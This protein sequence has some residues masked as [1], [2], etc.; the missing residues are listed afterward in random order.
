[1]TR[2]LDFMLMQELLKQSLREVSI[3]ALADDMHIK[4]STLHNHV[5][6]T[7]EPRLSALHKIG[8]YYNRY[9][10]ELIGEIDEMEG[11][12]LRMIQKLPKKRKKALLEELRGA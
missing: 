11:D 10:A 9:V 7:A 3:R 12:I 4:S 6:L 5:R 1:M 8:G 2:E